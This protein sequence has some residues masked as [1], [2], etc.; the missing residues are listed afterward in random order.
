MAASL[1]NITRT[2]RTDWELLPLTIDG[3]E[4]FWSFVARIEGTE[5]IVSVAGNAV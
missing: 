5:L 3:W 4:I 1:C 2:S